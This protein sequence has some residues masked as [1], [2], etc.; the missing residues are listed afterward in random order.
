MALTWSNSLGKIS[1]LGSCGIPT[2]EIIY[3]TYLG[4]D[5]DSLAK[6][7]QS[8]QKIKNFRR[9]WLFVLSYRKDRNN[10]RLRKPHFSGKLMTGM[11][12]SWVLN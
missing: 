4:K 1:C 10:G 7:A 11:L 8:F 6:K 5:F 3:M 2:L 9:F 12:F